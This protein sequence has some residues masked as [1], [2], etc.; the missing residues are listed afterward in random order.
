[1]SPEDNDPPQLGWL[2][3]SLHRPNADTFHLERNAALQT[4]S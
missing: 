2:T 4:T 1:L 3:T